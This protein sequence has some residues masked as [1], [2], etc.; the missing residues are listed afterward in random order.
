MQSYLRRLRSPLR[1]DPRPNPDRMNI[2]TRRTIHLGVNFILAPAPDVSSSRHLEFQGALA[3]EKVEFTKTARV[4]PQAVLV[5]EEGP[6]RFQVQFGPLP[7]QPAPVGQL[8]MIATAN[9]ASPAVE[10]GVS[11]KVFNTEASVVTDVFYKVWTERRQVVGRDATLR[12]LIDSGAQHALQYLWETRFSQQKGSLNVF[13]R[14][15]LG[16]GLRFMLPLTPEHEE[17]V[18]IKVESFLAD[19]SKIFLETTLKWPKPLTEEK[20]DPESMVSAL[21]AYTDEHVIPFLMGAE[22]NG[23]FAL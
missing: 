16:G 7:N 11:D 6:K 23:G 1:S 12:F 21:N 19:P 5:R 9:A 2:D 3:A 10:A 17:I 18:E 15:V 8:L 4:G 13:G 20:M 14:P 22:D